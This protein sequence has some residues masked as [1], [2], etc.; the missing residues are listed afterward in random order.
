MRQLDYW[1]ESAR[2]GLRAASFRAVPLR[3]SA[4]EGTP[5]KTRRSL[6]PRASLPHAGSRERKNGAVPLRRCRAKSGARRSTKA[7][8][9]LAANGRA[10][11]Q[12]N[13]VRDR[14]PA[15]SRGEPLAK[16]LTD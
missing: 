10:R 5:G 13:V 9:A 14:A 4:P 15:V 2:V 8:P 3:R 1:A 12:D 7:S 16:A 6:A 11:A